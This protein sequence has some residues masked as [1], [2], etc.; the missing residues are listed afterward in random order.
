VSSG[1]L[2]FRLDSGEDFIRIPVSTIA[3]YCPHYKN[4]KMMTRIS[5]SKSRNVPGGDNH[6][7]V[8]PSPKVVDRMLKSIGYGFASED[9]FLEPKKED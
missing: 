7:I 6:I 8:N 3:A 4:G 5:F 1:I 2:V 9:D